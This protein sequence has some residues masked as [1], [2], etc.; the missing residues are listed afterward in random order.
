MDLT[1]VRAGKA[2]SNEEVGKVEEK[3]MGAGSLYFSGMRTW[4]NWQ[5]R[6]T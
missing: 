6:R 2:E 3:M 4:R 5:T 1:E